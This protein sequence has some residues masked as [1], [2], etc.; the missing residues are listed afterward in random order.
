MTECNCI[1]CNSVEESY[2]QGNRDVILNRTKN[3]YE[4][5]EER[6][7]KQA[8]DKYRYLSKEAENK[9]TEYGRHKYHNLS[10]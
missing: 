8:R 9:K 1:A 3:Y 5:D 2:Y 10:K 6:L 4:D 7:K